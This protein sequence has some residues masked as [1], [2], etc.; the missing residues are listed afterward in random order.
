MYNIVKQSLN[1]NNEHNHLKNMTRIRIARK[2]ENREI[3]GEENLQFKG[4]VA[5]DGMSTPTR[6][7]TA[8]E[9]KG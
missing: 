2:G 4:G 8:E 5:H 6:W 9:E 1:S 3:S 7:S